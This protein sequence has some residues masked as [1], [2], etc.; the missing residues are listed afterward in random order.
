M[1]IKD[2]I[3]EQASRYASEIIAYRRHLHA[4][5]EL[6][7]EEYETSEFVYN[8]LTEFGL[9]PVKGI[10][11]TGIVALLK[12]KNPSKRILALRADMDALPIKEQNNVPYKSMNQGVM[13][14]CGHDVHTSSLLGT[15]KILNDIKDHMEGTIKLI[16]Q[17]GEEK[18]P[19]GASLMIKDGVLENPSPGSII[20]QHVMSQ[21]PVGKVGF[22]PGM[23]MASAD[24]IYIKVIGKGGHGA[25]PD[26]N[27][28]PVI[29]TAHILVALQQIVS[30]YANP[31]IPTVLSFGKVEANGATN[32]IPDEVYVEGTFRTLGEEWRYK[33]HERMRKLAESIARGMGADI[34]FTILNGYPFLYNEENLT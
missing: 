19:G 6:S 22:K 21:L 7:F 23:Y 11:G 20:G 1:N 33:A 10:G 16:F 8:K 26:N 5:P 9:K 32:V 31:K 28:D 34:E 17:P 29:I 27:I 15:A 3:K 25:M 14:A 13:H 18:I 12:G 2:T 30:R 24:E 4:H